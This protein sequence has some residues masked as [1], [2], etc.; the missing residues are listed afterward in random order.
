MNGESEVRDLL[1][2]AVGSGTEPPRDRSASVVARAGQLTRRAR[3][4]Y[5]ARGVGALLV[6]VVVAVLVVLPWG[7]DSPDSE[8]ATEG[9]LEAPLPPVGE[10]GAVF[11]DTGDPVFVV[12][13][14]DGEVSVLSAV[15]PHKP[16]VPHLVGWCTT[17]E[18]FED[19]VTG[20]RFDSHGRKLGGP[21]PTDLVSYDVGRITA[22]RVEVGEAIPPTGASQGE[23]PEGESCLANSLSEPFPGYVD[24]PGLEVHGVD[25][26]QAITLPEAVEHRSDRVI[27]L[28]PV[29]IRDNSGQVQL[30]DPSDVDRCVDAL[31]MTPAPPE[32]AAETYEMLFTGVFLARVRSADEVEVVA[33]VP[34]SDT[35]TPPTTVR[36][37][38][39]DAGAGW[40]RFE[41]GP[42]GDE[43]GTYQTGREGTTAV[44][45]GE[46]MILWGGTSDSG[47]A[48][49]DG[50]ALNPVT[51]TWR[52]I[53]DGPLDGRSGH[54]AVWANNE[55]IVWG[56][57]GATGSPTR[58]AYADGAA[59]D[60]ATDS[61]R[62]LVDP[63]LTG[64][65]RYAAVWTGS[66][67][68]IVG[69][70]D[71]DYGADG[72]VPATR[73]GEAAAYDPSTDTWRSLP[74]P[75]VDLSF[76][77]A[78]WTG[79]SV[80]VVG[81]QAFNS[82]QFQNRRGDLLA[83][84]LDPAS[85]TWEELPPAAI[86]A[87]AT[88]TVWAHGE[89]YALSYQPE[90]DGARVWNPETNTWRDIPGLPEACE[91]YPVAVGYSPG[92][93]AGHC[94]I[95]VSYDPTTDRWATVPT[96]EGDPAAWLG[97]QSLWTGTELL[98]L[99]ADG[100]VWSYRP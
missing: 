54:I 7:N 34:R 49:S 15:S 88:E 94:G 83:A 36:G 20:S 64:G 84:A 32:S 19:P 21:A 66:E 45:S 1:A 76:A 33:W 12:H 77:E 86:S 38:V 44:W 59:Y 25:A 11:V 99:T 10:V 39:T 53:A 3:L 13:H 51:E 92:V 6:V 69:G 2:S 71:Q 41:V 61:W 26:A 72:Q 37:E 93:L 74:G 90:L 50:A 29:S 43:L 52:S 18:T 14:A 42:L 73:Y 78:H 62:A 55:M 17:N 22:D 28:G 97:P 79:T 46:E 96:P 9:L 65:G 31:G 87:Q 68:V 8:L 82:P 80:L 75:P 67:V 23:L 100:V 16:V 98:T 85:G 5:A 47:R 60:P 95:V 48:Y 81:G 24:A 70:A 27:V 63:P 4:G 58:T 30:C 91:G 57:L 56:G 35:T 89:L 40:R